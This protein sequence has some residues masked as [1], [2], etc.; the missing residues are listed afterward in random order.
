MKKAVIGTFLIVLALVMGITSLKIIDKSCDELTAQLDVL[1]KTAKSGTTE[2]LNRQKVLLNSLWEK[3]KTFFHIFSNHSV[4]S[5]LEKDL[6]KLMYFTEKG[7]TESLLEACRDCRNDTQHI[8]RSS[9]P[10]LSNIF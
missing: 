4:T 3:K 5:E 2:E 10:S 8:K 7:D 1:S 6:G 9:E